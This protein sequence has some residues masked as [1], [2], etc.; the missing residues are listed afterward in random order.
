LGAVGRSTTD[1]SG[2]IT[3]VGLEGAARAG[4][5]ID[6]D[7]VGLRLFEPREAV[8]DERFPRQPVHGPEGDEERA[9]RP[10]LDPVDDLGGRL[11]LERQLSGAG[12]RYFFIGRGRRRP[13]AHGRRRDEHVAAFRLELALDGVEH[14]PPGRNRNRLRPPRRGHRRL[15][16]DRGRLGA[17]GQGG[18][19]EGGAHLAA[20]VVGHHA[21]GVQVFH[22]PPEAHHHPLARENP[23]VHAQPDRGRRDVF[24]LRE[25][26]LAFR[27][28]RHEN[29]DADALQLLN[30][31]QDEGV[32]VHRFVH[33]GHD[34][35]RDP[36]PKPRGD[37][38]GDRRVV[39]ARRDLADD[40]GR[41]RR[42]DD[43][44]DASGHVAGEGHV[45]DGAGELRHDRV[46]G[47][48][49]EEI[50]VDDARRR[51]AHDRAHFRPLAHEGA[52]QVGRAHGGH[53]AGHAQRD[54]F[55]REEVAVRS[56][57]VE[58]GMGLIH[59]ENIWRP[60]DDVKLTEDT[61]STEE[62]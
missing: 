55:A 24:G 16:R 47:G 38:R 44:V 29:G 30:V 41:G 60:G 7:E 49:V 34:Q 27:E 56:G 19:H 37:E 45:L 17:Q 9:R 52:R 43:E 14:L 5:V 26:G 2:A 32:A 40:V 57:D 13:I 62:D 48:P 39:D 36:L 23:A 3:V 22:R 61:E 58:G 15:A 51:V 21:D 12:R 59:G 8:R 33:G 28:A 50:G 20:R 35:E 4:R 6:G 54:F 10:L 42:D 25:L 31:L 11:E 1:P 53:A 46:P 18:P